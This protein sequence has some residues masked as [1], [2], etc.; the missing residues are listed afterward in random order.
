MPEN[1]GPGGRPMIV[2]S[3]EGC[4]KKLRVRP[5]LAGKKVG[6]PECKA[7]LQVPAEGPFVDEL[8]AV[9]V[10]PAPAPIAP[11]PLLLPELEEEQPRQRPRIRKEPEGTSPLRAVLLVIG[12]VVGVGAVISGAV[13]LVFHM[14][15]PQFPASDWRPFV[16]PEGGYTVSMPGTP[17]LDNTGIPPDIAQFTKQYVLKRAD[18]RM[19]YAVGHFTIQGGVI[20]D[21]LVEQVAQYERNSI[22]QNP[23]LKIVG[24][25]PLALGKLRGREFQVEATD[26]SVRHERFFVGQVAAWVRGWCVIVAGPR[27]RVDGPDGQQ[28]LNSFRVRTPGG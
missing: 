5:G 19:Q 4:G 3:C 20:N 22:G 26:G 12:A 9:L 24:E 23:K 18:G 7:A 13:W 28:F 16:P 21:A 1:P 17:A 25:R 15:A 6:C 27:K 14:P 11:A 10:E 2:L 8:E